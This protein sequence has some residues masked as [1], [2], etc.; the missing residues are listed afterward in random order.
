MR[1]RLAKSR[2]GTE[3]IGVGRRTPEKDTEHSMFLQTDL[4]RMA[5]ESSQKVIDAREGVEYFD[6][7]F[8]HVVIDNF[9]DPKLADAC[10]KN[11]P[12]LDSKL[13]DHANDKDIEIKYRTKWQSEFDIPDGIVDAV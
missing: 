7:P 1:R 13:W 10:L 2:P 3:I 9:L 4:K 5:T 6:E 8:R 12:A 11:F